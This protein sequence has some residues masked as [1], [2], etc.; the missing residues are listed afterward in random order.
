MKAV[1]LGFI[2]LLM[3]AGRARQG[4]GLSVGT[5]HIWAGFTIFAGECGPKTKSESM[6][7]VVIQSTHKNKETHKIAKLDFY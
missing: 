5:L 3:R 1:P 4:G 7:K 2:L 6:V